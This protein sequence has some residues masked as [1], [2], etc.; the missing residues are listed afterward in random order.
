MAAAKTSG[1]A[2]WGYQVRVSDKIDGR[3]AKKENFRGDERQKALDAARAHADAGKVAEVHSSGG[4]MAT[5]AQDFHKAADESDRASK[6]ANNDPSAHPLAAT[7]ALK[8]ADEHQKAGREASAELFRQRAQDHSAKAI[9]AP[10]GGDD[11]KR[12]DH[13]RFA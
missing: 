5:M 8:A 3:V 4:H 7:A 9:E 11:R 2:N 10:G 6:R 12:D 1:P 13:G